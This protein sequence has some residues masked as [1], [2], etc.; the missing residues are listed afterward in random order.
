MQTPHSLLSRAQTDP[1][2][3][4]H[5]HAHLHAG[6]TPGGGNDGAKVEVGALPQALVISGLETVSEDVQ[7][8]LWK[9]ISEKQLVLNGTQNL[10]NQNPQSPTSRSRTPKLEPRNLDVNG[11]SVAEGTWPLPEDFML[12]YVCSIGDGTERPNVQKT[13][14]SLVFKVRDECLTNLGRRARQICIERGHLAPACIC[15]FRN[16]SRQPT[17]TIISERLRIRRNR[18]ASRTFLSGETL[19]RL[20]PLTCPGHGHQSSPARSYPNSH[21]DLE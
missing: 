10:S 21:T 3:Y 18:P 5:A 12:V 17:A 2:P 8:A 14:V 1:V 20:F 7:L 4:M 9:V 19:P 13:L 11:Q 6:S 16:C 15:P